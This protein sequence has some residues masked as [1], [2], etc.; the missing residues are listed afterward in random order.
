MLW[1][2]RYYLLSIFFFFN[3]P[4][5]TEIYTYLHTLS[6]HDALPI[7]TVLSTGGTIDKYMGDCI[8]AFWNAPLDDPRHARNACEAA[9]AMHARLEDLN[10]EL[11]AE[12]EAAGRPA[13]ALHVGIGL[14]TG[15]CCVGNMGSAQR[16]D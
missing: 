6:L 14:N 13:I 11:T 7:Y 2:V 16:L 10:R 3:D 12:A 8:M 15:I 1:L 9:L 5:N 4:A